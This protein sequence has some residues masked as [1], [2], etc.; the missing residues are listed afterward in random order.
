LLD[1]DSL[2][3]AIGYAWLESV[4]GNER[5]VPLTQTLRSDLHLRPENQHALDIAGLGDSASSLLCLSDV[6]EASLTPFPSNRFV[7]VDHNVVNPRFRSDNTTVVGIVDH[8]AD[9][10]Y[11][12][13]ADPRVIA[14]PTGSCA[15]LVANLIQGSDFEVGSIPTGLAAL[16]L[17]AIVIDTNGLKLGGKAE[18]TDRAAAAFL[19]PL[20][21]TVPEMSLGGPNIAEGILQQ[22][23]TFTQLNHV[24]QDKKANVSSLSTKDLLRRDYKEYSFTPS[25]NS[26]AKVQVGLSTV[27]V[28][29]QPWYAKANQ[30]SGFW[31]EME[32]WIKERNLQ[33]LGVLTSFR[34][35]EHMNK[36][37]KPKH[38]REQ[39]WLLPPDAADLAERI[40]PG[41]E[42]NA[43]L[44]LKQTDFGHL[45]SDQLE[46]SFEPEWHA[47]IYKQQNTDATRKATAPIV[48]SI[49]EGVQGESG[50]L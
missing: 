36:K 31:R 20:A 23:S 25:W 45:G 15:S 28:G 26:S 47:S 7:L 10:G 32:S 40:F 2:A 18:P 27:P 48:K 49:I 14:V 50:R 5:I 41:L 42:S 30:N 35:T 9:E 29:L 38:R 22:E 12:L 21:A 44:D 37:G 19:A 3:S 11:H 13:S 33:A 16:L 24:L 43:E 8:H 4:Q 46:G 34:D 6:P 39:L 1:L 17:S